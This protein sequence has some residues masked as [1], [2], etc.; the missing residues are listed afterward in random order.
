[1]ISSRRICALRI[2]C[3]IT[4]EISDLY[5]LQ[6][7]TTGLHIDFC[8]FYH[9]FC[10]LH[11]LYYSRHIEKLILLILLFFKKRHC[12]LRSIR[13]PAHIMKLLR[14]YLIHDCCHMLAVLTFHSIRTVTPH[15]RVI[16]RAIILYLNI[17]SASGTVALY[18][19]SY[20]IFFYFIYMNVATQIISF[21]PL[22]YYICKSVFPHFIIPLLYLF[23]ISMNQDKF[24]ESW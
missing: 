10:K 9:L 13:L 6:C 1:M 14:F 21:A 23:L 3:V 16:R 22:K 11:I 17:V 20:E 8:L 5:I 15:R 19:R 24:F 2:F 12:V 4:F 18:C 7:Y